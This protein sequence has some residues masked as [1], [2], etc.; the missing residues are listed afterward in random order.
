MGLK[1]ACA[2]SLPPMGDPIRYPFSHIE[3]WLEKLISYRYCIVGTGEPGGRERHGLVERFTRDMEG[4]EI[5]FTGSKAKSYC[6]GRIRPKPDLGGSE[7]ILEVKHLA[8][9]APGG[10]LLKATITD[11]VTIGF[12]LVAND[13]SLARRYP[14]IYEDVEKAIE[15]IVLAISDYVDVVQFDCPSHLARPIREPWKH[16][17]ELS[18]K[19]R[20][21]T[22]LHI[23]GDVSKMFPA[24]LKEYDVDVINLNI[25]GKEEENNLKAIANFGKALEERGKKL[26]PAVVNTQIS[27]D[28]LEVEAVETILSRIVK[29]SSFL[30]LGELEAVTPGCGL[31]ILGNATQTILERLRDAVGKLD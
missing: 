21:R 3:F 5:R 13:P 26:A 24:L 20:K 4:V 12:E 17:N 15:P 6:T 18:R 31:R 10:V 2:G 28:V 14:E 19:V 23:D 29:L 27:D 9:V 25:H 11:P 16:L 30:D 1:L 8:K 22:W 7:E